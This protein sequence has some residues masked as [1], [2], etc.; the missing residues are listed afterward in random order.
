MKTCVKEK[1]GQE[2]VNEPAT[3]PVWWCASVYAFRLVWQK[4]KVCVVWA[5]KRVAPG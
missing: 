4:V 1:T 2:E 3:E 5:A